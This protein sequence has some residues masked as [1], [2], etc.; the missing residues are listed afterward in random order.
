MSYDPTVIHECHRCGRS[1][2]VRPIEDMNHWHFYNVYCSAWCSMPDGRREEYGYVPAGDDSV[3]LFLLDQARRIYK[4]LLSRAEPGQDRVLDACYWYGWEY[5]DVHP[6][7]F[8][9][10]FMDRMERS[11]FLSKRE[12]EQFARMLFALTNDLHQGARP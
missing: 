9:S 8:A 12:R 3:F 1:Y 7:R 4:N 5:V 2:A 10:E 6:Y 11:M